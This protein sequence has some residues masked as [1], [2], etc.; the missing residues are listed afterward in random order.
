MELKLDH[1]IAAAREVAKNSKSEDV[2]EAFNAFADLVEEKAN[3]DYILD[4]D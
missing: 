4:Q 1:I 3:T 2:K